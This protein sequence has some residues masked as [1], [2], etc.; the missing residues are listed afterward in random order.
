[1][2][3]EFHRFLIVKPFYH[4]TIAYYPLVFNSQGAA[5]QVAM[6]VTIDNRI[7]LDS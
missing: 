4:Y 5:G 1:M 3:L 2:T 6:L 7:A